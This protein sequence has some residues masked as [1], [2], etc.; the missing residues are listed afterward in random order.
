MDVVHVEAVVHLVAMAVATCTSQCVLPLDVTT[1][2]VLEV[3]QSIIARHVIMFG[4]HIFF[5]LEGSGPKLQ[6]QFCPV[7]LLS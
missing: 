5:I 7:A 2:H 3:V 6:W 4:G 1:V